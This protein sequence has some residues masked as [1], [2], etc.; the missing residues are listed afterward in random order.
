MASLDK[1]LAVLP[2]GGGGRIYPGH[3]GV[4]TDGH[5]GVLDYL[6]N[7]RM[8]ERQV[9]EALHGRTFGLSPLGITRLVYPKLSFILSEPRSAAPTL[10]QPP[11]HT[12]ACRSHL[13]L[14]PSRGQPS[15]PPPMC[16]R[17]S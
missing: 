14:D 12:L 17:R 8:R 16:T 15:P 3:G 11:C 7:R 13:V 10:H 1:A 5:Q 9:V 6:T 2:E 4:I